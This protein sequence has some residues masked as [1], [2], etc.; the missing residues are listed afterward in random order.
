MDNNQLDSI[1]KSFNSL[2]ELVRLSCENN[3]IR[4]IDVDAAASWSN[5]RHINVDNNLLKGL[6]PNLHH[7]HQLNYISC[8]KNKLADLPKEVSNRER[9]Y[10][11][12]AILTQNFFSVTALSAL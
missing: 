7:W 4:S 2:I 11:Y 1:P 8:R 9:I 10:I 5:L 6:P 3:A 12:I